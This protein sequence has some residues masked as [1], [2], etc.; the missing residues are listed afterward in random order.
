M[1]WDT[2]VLTVDNTSIAGPFGMLWV[3]NTQS[4]ADARYP[5]Q[6]GARGPESAR[7]RLTPPPRRPRRPGA[8]WGQSP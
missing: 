4:E 5:G 6:K 7:A 3:Y 8:S 1:R 2:A